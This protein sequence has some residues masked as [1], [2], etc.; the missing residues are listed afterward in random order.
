[1][2]KLPE[3]VQLLNFLEVDNAIDAWS[4]IIKYLDRDGKLKADKEYF[5]KNMSDHPNFEERLCMFLVVSGIPA[6]TLTV[7]CDSL[8]KVGYIH[9]VACKPEFRGR[10]LGTLLNDIALY[11]LK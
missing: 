8:T 3:N 1:M 6:A 11:T 5:T 9:M 4:D 10:G 7:I 2:P